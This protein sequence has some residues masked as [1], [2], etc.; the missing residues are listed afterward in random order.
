MAGA[1]R[2]ISTFEATIKRAT[3][4]IKTLTVSGKQVTQA[5]FRQIR[6]EPLIDWETRELRGVPWGQVN[7]HA[8]CRDTT[9]HEHLNLRLFDHLHVVWVHGEE[10]RQDVIPRTPAYDAGTAEPWEARQQFM[11]EWRARFRSLQTLDQL[12]IAV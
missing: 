2:R 12:F 7:Y 11:T 4:E 3:V 10:L 8:D 5:V 9:Y 6:R 1:G